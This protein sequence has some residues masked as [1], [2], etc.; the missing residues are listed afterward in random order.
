M[1][2]VDAL[3]KLPLSEFTSAR[4]TL[5]SRLK[6]AGRADEAERVKGLPKPSI[7]AWA[8]N[9]LF[10]NHRKEFDALVAAGTR[11][12]EAHGRQF[13]GKPADIRE[14][15]A[16]RR[17][18]LSVLS[19]LAE[20]VLR[21]AGHHPAPDTM[22]R[23]ETTL[24]ALSANTSADLM[25]GRLTAD[26][27]APGFDSLAG[28]IPS[29]PSPPPPAQTRVLT[30][31]Q[32]TDKSKSAPAKAALK[33]AE[34][35]LSEKRSALKRLTSA[36]K[37]ASVYRTEAEKARKEAEEKLDHAIEAAREARDL[38]D[39]LT[40]QVKEAAKAVEKA[41]REVEKARREVTGV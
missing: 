19:R 36:L 33:A 31:P 34:E 9:Q 18:A 26:V 13:T 2:D 10:W 30:F 24:E 29:I 6:K 3:Y 37:Q 27:A 11:L 22:R 16:A 41:E 4:N 32:S 39:G 35:S 8:V 25:P 23:I 40:G 17:E 7:S 14:P 38:E 5:A 21:G 28:L 15:L 20:S 1:E 12:L